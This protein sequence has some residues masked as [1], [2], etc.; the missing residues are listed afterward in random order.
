[1]KRIK[2]KYLSSVAN[3]E[4]HFIIKDSPYSA[5]GEAEAYEVIKIYEAPDEVAEPTVWDDMAAAIE[6][7]VND[8]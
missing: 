7:G 6:E 2:Y 3:G 8:V 5:E 4:R 1:M